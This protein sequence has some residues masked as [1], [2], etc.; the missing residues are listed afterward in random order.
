MKKQ[1][2][3]QIDGVPHG[4]EFKQGTWSGKM[5]CTVDGVETVIPNKF[6]YNYAGMDVPVQIGTKEC[7]LVRSG[8]M[9]D[10]AVDGIYAESGKPYVPLGKMP[11][12][13]WIFVALCLILPI[14]ALGGALPVILGI[15]GA[16]AC[17]RTARYPRK[18][19]SNVLRCVGITALCWVLWYVLTVI[20]FVLLY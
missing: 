9:L 3:I 17:A 11:G 10:I 12:W 16:A 18:T 8:K 4:V 15:L 5:S 7:R 13:A 19:A 6:T 14:A 2:I 20:L 1:W